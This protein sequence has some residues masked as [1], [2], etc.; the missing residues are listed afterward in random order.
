MVIAPLAVTAYVVYWTY[1]I[2]VGLPGTSLL[3]VTDDPVVNDVIQLTFTVALIIGM[4]LVVGYVVRTAT[5]VFMK[6][7][8]DRTARRIPVVGFFYNATQMAV[9]AVSMG[10]KEFSRP[11]KMD[12]SGIR[13]TGFR[14]GGETEDGRE[15]VFVPT[16]PNITSGLVVEID[17]ELTEDAGESTEEALTRVLSAGFASAKDE[18]EFAD[19]MEAFEGMGFGSLDEEQQTEHG[20]EGDVDDGRD[21][22]EE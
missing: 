18:E 6:N 4:L 21:G 10:K 12:F 13:I 5:G 22:R 3:R 17:P 14:T 16:S 1:T 20:E 15:M 9:E 19:Q 11:V 2:I 8:L 7:W